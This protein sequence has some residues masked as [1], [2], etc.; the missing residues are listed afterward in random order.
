ME[1]RYD[2]YR[3]RI[4]PALIEDEWLRISCRRTPPPDHDARVVARSRQADVFSFRYRRRA[5]FHKTFHP[6]GAAEP[7]KDW[8]RGSR[9]TRC[10]RAHRLLA[11]HGFRAPQVVMVGHARRHCFIVMAAVPQRIGLDDFL[12]N[13]AGDDARAHRM[14]RRAQIARLGDL[15]GRLHA[16][17]I[18][19][20]DLLRGNLMLSGR[21]PARMEVYFIDNE[22]TRRYRALPARARVRNLAQ[23]NRFADDFGVADRMRFLHQYLRHHPDLRAA[24]KQW[25]QRILD[26]TARKAAS[27]DDRVGG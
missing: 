26:R 16:A 8:F 20:G 11:A 27:G 4:S 15:I 21:D 14:H 19:H 9:A 1:H 23:L 25:I 3:L 10:L 5:Y 12:R 24:R 2:G 22:R 7:I 17:G 18:A 13:A 6:R